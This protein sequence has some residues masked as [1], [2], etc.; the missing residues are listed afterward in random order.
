M[1]PAISGL[2]PLALVTAPK[3]GTGKGLLADLTPLLMTGRDV[4]RT[5]APA[6]EEEWSKKLFSSLLSGPSVILLDNIRGVLK[7]A[8]LEMYLTANVVE[9]RVLGVSQMAKAP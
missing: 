7:S 3:A 2:T 9:G 5:N 1:R 6:K 4:M 8:S